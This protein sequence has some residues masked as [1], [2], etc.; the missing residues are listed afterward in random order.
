MHKIYSIAKREL[1][2]YFSTPVAFVF[3]IIIL[4]L[5]G[6]STFSLGEP[7]FFEYG[8]ADLSRFFYWHPRIYML[9]VPAIAMHLWSD[10]RRLGTI[11][12]LL[13]MPVP[14]H[15]LVIGKFLAS[16]VFMALCLICTFPII[17][18]VGYLGSPDF[19]MI[20]C[21]YLGSLFI[22]GIFLSVTGM[23]S[24]VARNQVVSFILAF[25][26]CFFLVIFGDSSVTDFFKT[27]LGPGLFNSFSAISVSNHFMTFQRGV[28]DFRNL[29]YFFSMITLPLY[30]TWIIVKNHR[31][32]K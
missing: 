30:L 11:E 3:M 26:I 4:L 10:E 29:F 31:S 7:D 13:T 12:L 14:A 19:G 8:T 1:I 2:S 6:F 9:M 28:I 5:F 20:F 23:T 25:M 16:W 21:G 17:I 32:G 24:A 18:A 15:Y 27:W 22:S